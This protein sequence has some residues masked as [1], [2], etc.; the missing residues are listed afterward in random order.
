MCV[1]LENLKER[2][3]FLESTNSNNIMT[4]PI[5]RAMDF[6]PMYKNCQKDELLNTRFLE[7]R[8]VNVPSSVIL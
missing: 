4:R 2:D 1:E 8:I 6:L 3:L 5:W 7:S